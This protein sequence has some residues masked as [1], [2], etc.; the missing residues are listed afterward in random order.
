SAR[1]IQVLKRLSSGTAGTSD[2]DR[3]VEVIDVRI[4]SIGHRSGH[5]VSSS[6]L[7]LSNRV[8]NIH[9]TGSVQRGRSLDGASPQDA[10]DVQ[11][12]EG[13]TNQTE[14]PRSRPGHARRS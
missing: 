4:V 14:I 6:A 12:R 13:L 2:R 10:D 8:R 1:V 5:A 9:R 3:K 11:N 7:I